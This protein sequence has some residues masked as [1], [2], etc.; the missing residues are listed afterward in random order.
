[1]KKTFLALLA[2]GLFAANASAIPYSHTNTYGFTT[3]VKEG[4][5]FTDVFDL[6]GGLFG[7]NPSTAQLHSANATFLLLMQTLIRK[8]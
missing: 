5:P 3:Q 1:M 2:S 6:T 7:Y 8:R 4:T